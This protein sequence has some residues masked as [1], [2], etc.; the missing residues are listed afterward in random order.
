MATSQPAAAGELRPR[1]DVGSSRG[2]VGGWRQHVWRGCCLGMASFFGLAA[3]VQKNDPDASLWTVAYL[4]PAAL[5]L[6]VA[7]SPSAAGNHVWKSVVHMHVAACLFGACLLA[8]VAHRSGKRMHVLEAEEGREIGG[9][10]L[11][12]FWM[13]LC[14]NSHEP[15]G[16]TLRA[17]LGLV[18]VAIPSLAW[19]YTSFNARIMAAN[20]EHCKNSL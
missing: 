17:G 9:L 10:L 14:R 7:V 13:I 2:L 12:V 18:L 8:A 20:P 4:F 15:H 3:Y 6:V 16:A 1:G 5:S 11:V 19:I